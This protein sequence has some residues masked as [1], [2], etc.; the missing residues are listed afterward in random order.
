[1][2]AG[3]HCG[4]NLGDAW[5]LPIIGTSDAPRAPKNRKE[6]RTGTTRS[7]G[8]SGNGPGIIATTEGAA[9]V[10]RESGLSIPP[11]SE[12]IGLRIWAS[13]C[14]LSLNRK[15]ILAQIERKLSIVE[16]IEA[17]VAANL[18]RAARLRQGILKRAFAG[19]LVPQDP[20][21]EPAEKWLERTRWARSQGGG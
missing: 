4:P 21:D 11:I 2:M 16:E 20:T 6:K 5:P 14:R 8:L 19:R 9:E 12:P 3:A 1:M 13:R 10:G 7:A 18:K 17:Q 15:R